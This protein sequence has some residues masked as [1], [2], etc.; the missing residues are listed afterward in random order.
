MDSSWLDAKNL[1]VFLSQTAP[2]PLKIRY[3]QIQRP[4]STTSHLLGKQ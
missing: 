3:M 4:L 2:A 1:E